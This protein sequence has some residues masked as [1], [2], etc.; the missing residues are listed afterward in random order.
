VLAALEKAGMEVLEVK[1]E[2]DWCC[3]VARLKQA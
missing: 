2:N 1:R 3:T